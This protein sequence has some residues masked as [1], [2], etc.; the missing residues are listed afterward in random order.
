MVGMIIA[1]PGI[2]SSGLDKPEDVDMD[3]VRQQMERMLNQQD[4]APPALPTPDAGSSPGQPQTGTPAPGAPVPMPEPEAAA[5]AQSDD[6]LLK[7]L[8]RQQEQGKK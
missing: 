1:F 7:D 5:P 2:V 4:L 8:Q 6:D 3:K